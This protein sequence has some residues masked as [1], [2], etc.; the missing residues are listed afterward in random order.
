VQ[1]AYLSAKTL[2]EM[3]KSKQISSVELLNY[4]FKR[5]N[6]VN[7]KINAIISINEDY[8]IKR[9]RSADNAVA[10][11]EYLGALHG[12][13]ITV[14]DVYEVEGFPVSS[15][16][17]FYKEHVVT[18]N[19]DIVQRLVDEGAVIF[20]KT[21]VPFF[22]GDWQTYNSVYGTT[23]NPWNTEMTC[24]GSSGGPAAALAAG[25]TPVEVGSDLGGSI[26]IPAHY[27]GV[28]GH[29]PT[30]GITSI[31]GHIPGEPGDLAIPDLSS[32]GVMARTA[33]DLELMLD[34]VCGA[35]YPYSVGW[36]LELPKPKAKELKEYR[37]FAW[38]YD[39]FCQIDRSIETKYN[40][41]VKKLIENGVSV[42]EGRPEGYELK[43][44]Y[45]I[46]RNLSG[47]VVSTGL[48]LL[49][50]L[51]I[52]AII[53]F[54]SIAKDSSLS[55]SWLD[56]LKG[57]IQGHSHWLEL[58]E[59]RAKMKHLC[60][61]LFDKYDVLITP[62]APCTAF[63]HNHRPIILR[64][65]EI[66]GIK[67]PYTDHIPWIAPATVFGLPATSVPVGLNE[68]GMP[69]NLQVIGGPF[70][71]RV[72]IDFAKKLEDASIGGFVKP[73]TIE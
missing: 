48:P 4:F 62:V 71:D 20:G 14:K 34:V 16:T 39:D 40:E 50:R 1:Y 59:Q 26:R 44:I 43:E 52:K 45:K 3:I 23:N 12:L 30:Y 66:N 60:A 29:R 19:A 47:S 64:K 57:M 55:R 56:Y 69:V 15:G 65:L 18:K 67:R 2:I 53:P 68:K 17:P 21:N 37:V 11:G 33:D 5:V 22:A 7:P 70:M 54:L 58:D 38:F 46:M 35:P 13:P 32:A 24:G 49:Y 27:C 8:A 36:K 63:P 61:A 28:Y 42:T 10:R 31:R 51:L 72:T 6:E 9:A 25:L 73:K 41:V